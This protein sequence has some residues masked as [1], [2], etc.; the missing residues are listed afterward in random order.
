LRDCKLTRVSIN[1]ESIGAIFGLTREQ[2]AQ[3]D[4]VYLGEEE[5]IPPG[6][7][8]LSLISEEYHRRKWH[9]GQLVLAVNFG[10]ASTINAFDDYLSLSYKRFT[11]FGFAKGEELEFL[12]DLLQEL[13]F[14]ERLPLLTA[15]NVLEWCTALEAAIIQ[16]N[17]NQPESAGDSLRTLA[18]RVAILTNALLDRLDNSLPQVES[19]ENDRRL[20]IKATFQEKPALPLAD[21]LNSLASTS[22]LD[23]APKSHLVRVEK[24]SYV[25]IVITTIS[26]IIAFQVVLFLIN[27]C[28]IQLTELKHR[29]KVLARKKAPR[30]YRNLVLSTSQQ[31]SPLM[32][33]ILPILVGHVKSLPWLKDQS[34][35]GYKT[36]NI[37]SLQEV[38]C[39][40]SKDD[41]EE[42]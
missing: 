7:D 2:L 35:S 31:A 28:V 25:E 18:S 10:L 1:A 24:G 34:L 37:K 41:S 21:F 33:S 14:L 16:S 32:L 12:G 4:M 6:T 15:L 27:G 3:A 13:A 22:A 38:Q 5:P 42:I 26:T 36:S 20:C 17:L 39:E 11:E 8:I 30:N 40:D 9:I 19:G 23:A 29:A